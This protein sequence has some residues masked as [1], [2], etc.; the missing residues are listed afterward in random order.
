MLAGC[1]TIGGNAG[2]TTELIDNGKNGL[3]YEI[4]NYKDLADKI[5][6]A[7]KNKEKSQEMINNAK[8]YAVDNFDIINYQKFINNLYNDIKNIKDL[9]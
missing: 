8:R 1:L 5:E 9:K 7:I 4:G 6:Y 3:L 2:A